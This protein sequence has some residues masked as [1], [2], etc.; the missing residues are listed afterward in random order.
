[1][2]TDN[3]A[4]TAVLFVGLYPAKI[5]ISMY[6][7]T[8]VPKRINNIFRSDT[9]ITTTENPS[10]GKKRRKRYSPIATSKV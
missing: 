10:I 2:L 9:I 8:T 7:K 5:A 1:M 6:E 4:N 3:T